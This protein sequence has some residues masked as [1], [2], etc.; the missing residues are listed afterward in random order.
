MYETITTKINVNLLNLKSILAERFLTNKQV[1]FS[2]VFAGTWDKENFLFILIAHLF[3]GS[4]YLGILHSKESI[5]IVPILCC[6]I[7]KT[8]YIFISVKWQPATIGIETILTENPAFIFLLILRCY[9]GNVLFLLIFFC[10]SQQS[11]S[12]QHS[13]LIMHVLYDDK[14][15]M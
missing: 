12:A 9:H 2:L 10:K 14:S 1:G 8:P 13:V 4:A 6:C 11:N 15:T 5:E 3:G 7:H